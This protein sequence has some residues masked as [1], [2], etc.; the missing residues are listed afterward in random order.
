[1]SKHPRFNHVALS[2]P[3]EKL[4]DKGRAEILE[5]CEQVFGWSEFEQLTEDRKT[6]VLMA[7]TYGQFVYLI[8]DKKP[9][10]APPKDHFGMSVS[11]LEEFQSYYGR[12]VAWKEL[13]D[14]ATLVPAKVE[15]FG[16]LKLHSFYIGDRL[17]LMVEVQF[18][19]WDKAAAS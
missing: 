3:A 16:P 12:A 13:H 18:F 5:F 6:L 14:E 7:Y 2:M 9:L 8:A 17:P 19:E 4:D 11:S 10:T 1:M 15:D